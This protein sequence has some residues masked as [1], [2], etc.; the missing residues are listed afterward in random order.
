MRI[1]LLTLWA[2]ILMGAFGAVV[3]GRVALLMGES[4]ANP[5]AKLYAR[6]ISNQTAPSDQAGL[7][8]EARKLYQGGKCVRTEDLYRLASVLTQSNDPTDLL[9]AHDC[10]LASL[11]EGF[12]PSARALKTSQKRLLHSIGFEWTNQ[13][14]SR[15][16]SRTPIVPLLEQFEASWS[17]ATKSVPQSPP[18]TVGLAVIE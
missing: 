13:I 11:I 7:R 9:L 17:A 4:E 18:G 10:A 1:K 14:S 15:K 5:V 16:K 12:R 3:Q 2:V 8:R 6:A